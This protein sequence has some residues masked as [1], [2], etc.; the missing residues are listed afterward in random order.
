[1]R[2][3]ETTL[4]MVSAQETTVI[5]SSLGGFYATYVAEKHGCRAVLLQPAVSPHVG[6][7]AFLGT[8]GDPWDS[9]KDMLLASMGALVSMLV[10]AL[11][12]W[13]SQ[14]DF[15]REWADSLRVRHPQPLGEE[16]L[17][18]RAGKGK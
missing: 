7:E 3:I 18:R 6:L 12:N 9:H 10:T 17:A 5:G 2:A 11:I 8:Q 1:M 14:R 13:R 4:A 15:G 16:A